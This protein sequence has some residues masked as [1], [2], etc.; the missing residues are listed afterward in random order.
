[1]GLKLA[2]R[3]TVTEMQSYNGHTLRWWSDVEDGKVTDVNVR[4]HRRVA[5]EANSLSI[6]Q[7]CVEKVDDFVA[8]GLTVVDLQHVST[9]ILRKHASKQT[10][11][12]DRVP[13][14]CFILILQR[15]GGHGLALAK[16]FTSHKG[17]DTGSTWE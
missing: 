2:S 14:A 7:R 3:K 11:N 9:I 16:V 15:V 6:R 5:L 4:S 13:A 12:L 8:N 1:M 10:T 17:I